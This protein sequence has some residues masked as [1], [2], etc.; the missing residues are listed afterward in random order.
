[1]AIVNLLGVPGILVEAICNEVDSGLKTLKQPEEDN[2]DNKL[3]NG[4]VYVYSEKLSIP[5]YNYPIGK[6]INTYRDKNLS[7]CSYD[8]FILDDIYQNITSEFGNI[9]EMKI[10]LR[11]S[12]KT[13]TIA[14]LCNPNENG[15]SVADLGTYTEEDIQKDKEIFKEYTT[16]DIDNMIRETIRTSDF[17]PDILSLIDSVSRSNDNPTLLI[18]YHKE[19]YPHLIPID[20]HPNGDFVDLRCAEDV[21]LK[22][23][24]FKLIPF[25]VS[26]KLPKG[27]WG[28]VVPR[29]STFKRYGI[30]QV[31]SF[32]VIDESYCGDN[33]EW[34]MPVYAT[35]DTM[36]Y[37]NN[38][39]AQFRIV[40]KQ[41]FEMLEVY[42]LQDDNRG[43]FGSTGIK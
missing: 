32:G 4:K 33:D 16:E 28:Q 38:R 15:L 8:V 42:R 29:S 17:Y 3:D 11:E 2:L 13:G 12:Y 26:I 18:R 31:N 41:S 14:I 25:G 43:G 39:I 1:M 10:K 19:K 9:K 27:Y 20:F 7:I 22:A 35:R 37:Q 30:I 36:I 40:K 5:R 24:E 21:E 34:M 23:G 6:I